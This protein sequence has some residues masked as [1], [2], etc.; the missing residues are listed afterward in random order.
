MLADEAM[1]LEFILNS[2]PSYFFFRLRGVEEEEDGGG[3]GVLVCVCVCVGGGCNLVVK[4][5]LRLMGAH[6]LAW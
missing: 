3:D 6:S 1:I 4:S 2:L 5:L